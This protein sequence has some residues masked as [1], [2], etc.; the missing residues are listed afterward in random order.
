MSCKLINEKRIIIPD[1][2]CNIYTKIGKDLYRAIRQ[3]STVTF[4]REG[5]PVVE[6][7]GSRRMASMMSLVS[8]GW[9]LKALAI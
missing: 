6:S 1:L 7:H 3:L 4:C 2:V 9:Q 5:Q 8:R